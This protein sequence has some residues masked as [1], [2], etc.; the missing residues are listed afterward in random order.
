MIIYLAQLLSNINT[1]TIEYVDWDIP[2]INE[3]GSGGAGA[4][5][6]CAIPPGYRPTSSGPWNNFQHISH[7][8][9]FD[10]KF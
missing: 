3:P 1:D 4:V 5:P 9:I 6:T 7:F 8:Y 2:K 10:T